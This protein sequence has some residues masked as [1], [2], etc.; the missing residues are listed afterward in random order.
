MGHICVYCHPHAQGWEMDYN[1]A[2]CECVC[3][4]MSSSH[5]RLNSIWRGLGLPG[6]PVISNNWRRVSLILIL[7]EVF[8]TI[9]CFLSFS[10][11]ALLLYIY[12]SSPPAVFSPQVWKPS[13]RPD[14]QG[15][16]FFITPNKTAAFPASSSEC[17]RSRWQ[18]QNA[19]MYLIC[20]SNSKSGT[21]ISQSETI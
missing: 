1:V 11:F 12:Y 2:D 16:F 14:K 9:M 19:T 4:C 17:G 10:F 15:L 6:S 21:S 7:C 5:Y 8:V 20:C 3:I 18:G 13:Y